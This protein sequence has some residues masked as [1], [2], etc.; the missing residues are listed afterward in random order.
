MSTT[1]P[2]FTPEELREL[3][4]ADRR[5]GRVWAPASSLASRSQPLT[6]DQRR[7]VAEY[8]AADVPL[9]RIAKL[10]R[11]SYWRLKRETGP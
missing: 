7:Q 2:L 1:T 5:I 4:I 3:A 10:M 8:R 11:V 6:D 9:Y